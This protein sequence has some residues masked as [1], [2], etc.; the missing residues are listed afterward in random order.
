MFRTNSTPTQVE[1]HS[2]RNRLLKFDSQR[3]RH[4]NAPWTGDRYACVFY[5]KDLNYV[6]S[7][8][9]KRSNKLSRAKPSNELVWLSTTSSAT[10]TSSAV[11]DARARLLK[12]LKV[13][14]FPEDRTSGLT[15]SSKYGSKRGTFLAFG[16]T[17]SRKN[18]TL[19]MEHG[20]CTRKNINRNNT[21]YSELYSALSNYVN[22]LHPNLFGTKDS[23]EYHACIVAKNSQCEW[24]VDAGNVGPCV[25]TALGDFRGGDLMVDMQRSAVTTK[26]A[27]DTSKTSS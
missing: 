25:I 19:R 22:L 23:C 6:G 17:K 21:K 15:P 13:T 2:I 14:R 26:R 3:I 5:N 4:K 27:H 7:K 8:M 9:C 16:V 20:M 1:Q 10:T 18:R 11:L 12:I 24:H